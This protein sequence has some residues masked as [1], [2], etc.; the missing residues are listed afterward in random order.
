MGPPICRGCHQDHEEPSILR[1]IPPRC[2]RVPGQNQIMKLFKVAFPFLVPFF[3]LIC[4][5]AEPKP[6]PKPNILLV[7]A[8]QWRAQA[9]G[10]AG[11]PNVKTP[12][13]DRLASQSINF[14][15]A[16]AGLPVCCPTRASL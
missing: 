11:D 10:F 9:F 12:N 6:A 1:S 8:D 5:A 15:N 4:T 2:Y 14:I 3:A 13:L 7:I 16:V